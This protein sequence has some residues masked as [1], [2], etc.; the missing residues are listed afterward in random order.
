VDQ[1]V[2]APHWRQRHSPELTCALVLCGERTGPPA[3][4]CF[5]AKEVLGR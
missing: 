5:T 1:S 3:S 4:L 2:V